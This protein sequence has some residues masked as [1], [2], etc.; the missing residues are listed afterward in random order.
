MNLVY[1]LPVGGY[2]G[3]EIQ[4]VKRAQDSLAKGYKAIVLTKADSK[5]F[6]TAKK[7]GIP[8]LPT[9][10]KR[11][12]F[13]Y[14]AIKQLGEIFKK[15]NTDICIC[16]HSYYLSIALIARRLF[17]P[18]TAV[19]FYQQLESAVNKKDFVHNHIYK[20]LDGAVVLTELM[21]RTLINNTVINSEKVR[22]IPYGIDNDLYDPAQHNKAE[23]RQKF[24]LPAESLIF[25]LIGRI[26]PT[27]GQDL[28]VRSF[29]RSNIPNSKLVICGNIAYQDYFDDLFK[30]IIDAGRSEDLVYIPFTNDVAALMNCFDVFLLP[31]Q[32]EAFGL[33]VA[34]A[35][36]SGLPVIATKHGGVPEIIQ[37]QEN[38]FLF[39]F[40]HENDLTEIMLKVAD[41][42]N[43]RTK[44]G[45]RAR[46]TISEKFDYE[47]QTNKFFEFCD[48]VSTRRIT[49]LII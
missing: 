21:K 18:K 47:R 39:H 35:M 29:I 8:V 48:E 32:S 45:K 9:E 25:G 26:E 38:G 4:M 46:K 19:V 43:L 2:G 17:N 49:K 10:L 20:S 40:P 44:I 22:A 34:E 3:L 41:D 31:S 23:C 16:G 36:S 1:Y 7:N 27:K 13:D 15:E 24:N 42:E 30:F 12:Y 14:A 5:T 37:D 11:K 33:V 28:A 6:E